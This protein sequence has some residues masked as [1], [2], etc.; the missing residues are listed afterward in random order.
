MA[1]PASSG[2][3]GRCEGD[4]SGQGV[5]HHQIPELPTAGASWSGLPRAECDRGP[6]AG[7]LFGVH[8]DSF[9]NQHLFK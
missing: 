1:T 6:V 5:W 8:R 7:A 4:L 3:Q 2:S 9:N